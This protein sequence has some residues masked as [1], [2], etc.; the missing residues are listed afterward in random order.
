[1]VLL[2]YGGNICKEHIVHALNVDTD[3]IVINQ[4][5]MSAIMMYAQ[6]VIVVNLK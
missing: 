3:A 5:V 6:V 2:F 4:V 1:M